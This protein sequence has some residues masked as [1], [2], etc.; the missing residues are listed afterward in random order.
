MDSS[1]PNR[2]VLSAS[3]SGFELNGG[4]PERAPG[5]GPLKEQ[6]NPSAPQ[7]V[8]NVEMLGSAIQSQLTWRK[9]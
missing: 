4:H 2:L 9:F 1:A 6:T 5:L 8:E 7:S 3:A